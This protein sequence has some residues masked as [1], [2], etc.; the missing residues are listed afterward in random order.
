MERGGLHLCKGLEVRAE[1]KREGGLRGEFSVLKEALWGRGKSSLQGLVPVC[2]PAR[3][4]AHPLPHLKGLPHT[5]A[6]TW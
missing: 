4:T 1:A 6:V 3:I 2:D 5:V